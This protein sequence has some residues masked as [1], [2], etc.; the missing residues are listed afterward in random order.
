MLGSL[1]AFV[2]LMMIQYS[3]RRQ[4][5]FPLVSLLFLRPAHAHYYECHLLSTSVP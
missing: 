1:Y 5:N 4:C 2:F 3:A